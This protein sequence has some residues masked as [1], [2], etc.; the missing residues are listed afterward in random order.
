[1]MQ[2]SHFQIR[3]PATVILIVAL[4]ACGGGGSGA[5]STGSAVVP[6]VGSTSRDFQDALAAQRELLYVPSPRG[7]AVF[8]AA[9][10]GNVKPLFT[11][12]TS[13]NGSVALD[14]RG[15]VYTTCG[16]TV[17]ILRTC[18]TVLGRIQGNK[19]MLS[20]ADQAAVDTAGTIYVA[21]ES[22]DGFPTP[23]G[24]TEYAAG[25]TGNVAPIAQI[26]GPHTFVNALIGP[27]GVV[28]DSQNNIYAVD[29]NLDQRV[30][31]FKAGSRGDVAPIQNIFGG[32]TRLFNPIS[33]A[34]DSSR[35]IYVTNTET[36]F[37]QPFVVI[38]RPGATGNV[39]PV[40]TITS[41]VFV[42]PIGVA[43]GRTGKIYVSDSNRARTAGVVYVFAPG[44]NGIVNPI[45]QISG[46]A[47]G[48][49]VGF[50]AY[51]AVH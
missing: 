4:S 37:P 17:E 34:V 9:A 44:A 45:A 28:L 12:P 26:T 14:S 38:Y 20:G 41:S 24:I 31:V 36:T 42:I 50:G 6:P 1:M 46:P 49:N 18:G 22:T 2:F 33:I 51:I 15:K 10:N 23:P 8:D 7:I 30:V 3:V 16:L 21:N 27:T 29:N 5:G 25:A 11:I 48:L 47:T 32:N 40:A 19:T 13:C 43:I 39:A 35:R